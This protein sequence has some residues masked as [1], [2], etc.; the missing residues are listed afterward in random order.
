[1]GKLTVSY[2]NQDIIDTTSDGSFTLATEGKLMAD[3]VGV[4]FEGG[5]ALT[6]EV[7]VDT[8]S[9]VTATNGSQTVTGTSVNGLCTLSLPAAG[10]WTVS[11]EKDGNASNS[12][13][14][15]YATSQSVTLSFVPIAYTSAQS[16]VTYT[17]GIGGLSASELNEIAMTISNNS[18]ITS[19]TSEVWVSKYNRHI[20]TGDTTSISVSDKD[21]NF[22]IIGFN[23]DE[24]TTATA[25]GEETAT[26]KAG[27]TFQMVDCLDTRYPMNSS[28]TNS[29]GWDSCAMRSTH[30]PAIKNTITST[31]TNIM[32]TV[33]KKASA[34]GGSSTLS[35]SNDVLF[36]FST[37]EIFGSKGYALSGEGDVYAYWSANNTESARIKK[38]NGSASGWWARSPQSGSA[39]AFCHVKY[40]GAAYVEDA[41]ASYG[42]AFGFCV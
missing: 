40:D 7:N 39:K 36:L 12:D 19:T 17:D 10:T 20:S 9:A 5:V 6:L 29:G 8:G 37:I 24:L 21:Y 31:W 33:K 30:L 27:I 28:A 34:G 22:R 4:E 23:H 16:G 35:S 18:G 42:V 13:T 32:K 11:A 26:G 38:V 2:N 41:S 1:M 14:K 3:D 25:Y 15:T